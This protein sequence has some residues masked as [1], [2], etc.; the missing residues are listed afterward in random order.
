MS[1]SYNKIDYRLRVAKSVERRMLCSIFQSLDIFHPIEKYQYIGFG[2]VSFLDFSLF[3]RIMGLSNM[4]SMEREE[5]DKSRF[6]FNKP[7]DC[8]DIKYGDSKDVLPLINIDNK[9]IIWLDYDSKLTTDILSDIDLVF[10]R[11]NSGS[12]FCV[13]YNAQQ[14]TEDNG[15]TRFE[16][17]SERIDNKYFPEYLYKNPH[18]NKNQIR[19]V[20]FDII[21]NLIKE[22]IKNRKLNGDD[23]DAQQVLFLNYND[24][25]EMNTLG[26]LFYSEQDKDKV[27][28][29]LNKEFSF[30]SI[31]ESSFEIKVP[32]LTYKEMRAIEEKFPDIENCLRCFGKTKIGYGLLNPS[33]IRNYFNIY[34]KFSLFAEINL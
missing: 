4:I 19:K 13:S 29:V 22:V 26:W 27:Q 33:D 9:T 24:G 5:H 1:A 23:I 7:Y 17:L 30:V 32:A 31:G 11:L 6:E 20:Y 15:K 3:H 28:S 34:K 8:I 18:L 21:N 16:K 12:F 10:N 25:A 14:D 2:S